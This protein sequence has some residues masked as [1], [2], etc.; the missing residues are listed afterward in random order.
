MAD[1]YTFSSAAFRKKKAKRPKLK[2]KQEP[3]IA[4]ST[5]ESSSQ[6]APAPAA[7]AP[8][9]PA[10]ASLP[11]AL[12]TP[13]P[14]PAQAQVALGSREDPYPEEEKSPIESPKHSRSPSES[15]PAQ[16]TS[17]FETDTIVP[18]AQMIADD[19]SEGNSV[20]LNEAEQY[21]PADAPGEIPSF[22]SSVKKYNIVAQEETSQGFSQITKNSP[23]MY[24]EPLPSFRAPK[25]NSRYRTF[26]SG[27]SSSL[28]EDD[29]GFGDE[30]YESVE[31]ILGEEELLVQPSTSSEDS[32]L[33]TS[34][35]SSN[36]GKVADPKQYDKYR[37]YFKGNAAD[38]KE[39]AKPTKKVGA[40]PD[41]DIEYRYASSGP[42][43][44]PPK[45]EQKQ[46]LKPAKP[47][48]P[49]SDKFSR[50]D[51]ATLSVMLGGESDSEF[52]TDAST[53]QS[54][55][56]QESVHESILSLASRSED[57]YNDGILSLTARSEHEDHPFFDNQSSDES[58][59]ELRYAQKVIHDGEDELEVVVEDEENAIVEETVKEEIV[60]EEEEEE[61]VE[62]EISVDEGEDLT[63]RQQD[64]SSEEPSTSKRDDRAD[65]GKFFA[66]SIQKN[67]L[68]KQNKRGSIDFS[69]SNFSELWENKSQSSASKKGR[70]D[71][72]QAKKTLGA[73]RD[74]RGS[75]EVS[76]ISELWDYKKD[77]IQAKKPFGATGDLSDEEEEDNSFMP[78]ITASYKMDPYSVA[79][80]KKSQDVKPTPSS[81]A[82]DKSSLSDS[83]ALTGSKINQEGNRA[84]KWAASVAQEAGDLDSSSESSIDGDDGSISLGK[85]EP[86]RKVQQSVP[87]LKKRQDGKPTVTMK[88]NPAWAASL[89]DASSEESSDDSVSL[90]DNMFS[91]ASS[92]KNQKTKSK[93]GDIGDM[94]GSEGSEGSMD[95]GP[96]DTGGEKQKRKGSISE[97]SLSDFSLGADDFLGEN[98][99]SNFDLPEYIPKSSHSLEVD[100]NQG[101][102]SL[103][104][105]GILNSDLEASESF[106]IDEPL[107]GKKKTKKKTKREPPKPGFLT[108]IR[109]ILVRGL[110][111]VVIL[112]AIVVPLYL[113]VFDE[114]ITSSESDIPVLELYPTPPLL[115][116][117]TPGDQIRP[118]PP[119]NIF[120]PT[121]PDISVPPA[122]PPTSRPTSSPILPGQTQMPT[123]LPTTAPT[124]SKI[125]ALRDFL[126][127]VFP[128]LQESFVGVL[129]PQYLSLEWVSNNRDLDL[130]SD[131]KIIQRFVLS[132]VYFSMDGDRWRNNAWWLTDED[133]C[134]WHTSTTSRPPCDETG[135]I[136]NLHLDLNDVSGTIPPELAL[137]S[138]SLSR[139]DFSRANSRGS[140]TGTIPSELGLL[141]RLEFVSFS[142]NNLS[143]SIPSEIGNWLQADLVDFGHNL[144]TGEIP[145]E[146]G[147]LTDLTALHLENNLLFGSLPTTF[148]RLTSMK[149]LY[150]GTNELT[151]PIPSGIGN[152]QQLQELKMETNKFTLI[153]TEIGRLILLRTLSMSDNSLQ[154]TIPTELGNLANLLSLDLEKNSLT[155]P[156]PAEIGNLFVIRGKFIFMLNTHGRNSMGSD[157][158]LLT[159]WYHTDMLNLSNNK[160]S[161][162]IPQDFGRLIFLSKESVMEF[163][164]YFTMRDKN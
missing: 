136:V 20:P 18:P 26:L 60:E 148:G 72:I 37:Q 24:S 53:V 141:T 112:A 2:I 8:E 135:A 152:L 29:R 93:F 82:S 17:K 74:S 99:R 36:P 159:C 68:E 158:L 28:E 10:Q 124:E 85:K 96:I 83:K 91:A 22:G 61:E 104:A 75:L 19:S 21:T 64:Q 73:T 76:R 115:A 105:S 103:D 80:S 66:S 6:P 122:V 160:L 87:G 44:S 137:L 39:W 5:E 143:G 107:T 47:V 11:P 139:I 55:S 51:M 162:S 12:A 59:D 56:V 147:L 130:F 145:K 110:C 134:S 13:S 157:Q 118:T 132:T 154:A 58:S 126:V 146:I 123:R 144:L 33:D 90:G 9:A 3:T 108:D 102:Q 52:D 117:S 70:D 114:E 38:E 71:S 63:E 69:I 120:R 111:I 100:L 129:S 14:Q 4:E 128:S 164:T 163:Q 46:E 42:P 106:R 149:N 43:P 48:I 32:K 150:L 79:S 133:E 67:E 7:P 131:E 23:S 40:L 97:D 30:G 25:D 45:P 153:P 84:G 16:V 119:P 101:F 27:E 89:A 81:F 49:K 65:L 92:K 127:S 88:K 35:D 142:G 138:N 31:E 140:I 50:A 78:G 62:E 161:G 121:T 156:I 98:S 113:F 94:E 125:V 54:E 95:F 155:G 86:D 151:G 15:R 41:I 34:G 116:P 57:E 77:S 1:E 109:R